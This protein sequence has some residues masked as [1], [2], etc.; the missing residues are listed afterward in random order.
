MPFTIA[1]IPFMP[2]AIAVESN[3]KLINPKRT[4]FILLGPLLR[5]LRKRF[6]NIHRGGSAQR[7]DNRVGGQLSS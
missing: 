2:A 3:K 4:L 1:K 7:L 5:S 6:E